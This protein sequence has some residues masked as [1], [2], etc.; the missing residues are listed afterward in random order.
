MSQT[1][2]PS[3][4]ILTCISEIKTLALSA[5]REQDRKIAD[6][7]L[8]CDNDEMIKPGGRGRWKLRENNRKGFIDVANQIYTKGE[9][10][11]QEE[12][13]LGATY[14]TSSRKETTLR[15]DRATITVSVFSS[16][17]GFA[18]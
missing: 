1:N 8:F 14:G 11:C 4:E 13:V 5:N 6:I 12:K 10:G 17:Y 9:L 2:I 3:S 15:T 16:I 18:N 7:Q